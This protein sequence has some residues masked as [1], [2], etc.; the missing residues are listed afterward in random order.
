VL[1]V[2]ENVFYGGQEPNYQLV[3]LLEWIHRKRIDV[4]VGP[5]HSSYVDTG[6]SNEGTVANLPDEVRD[7]ISV[8]VSNAKLPKRHDELARLQSRMSK[9]VEQSR[10]FN[11]D[12]YPKL[13]YSQGELVD[14]LVSSSIGKYLEFKSLSNLLITTG[15]TTHVIPCSKEDIFASESLGLADKRRL[16]KALKLAQSDTPISNSFSEHLSSLGLTDTLQD[17]VAN[18]VAATTS[19]KDGKHFD[20]THAMQRV[21]GFMA[22][23]GRYGKS[24]ILVP[25][26]GGSSEISQAFC[27]YAAV[28]GATYVLGTAVSDVQ[29]RNGVDFVGMDGERMHANRLV[30]GVETAI[31]LGLAKLELLEKVQWCMMLLS[32]KL[33]PSLKLMCNETKVIVLS[34][35]QDTSTCPTDM[36]VLWFATA[37]GTEPRLALESIVSAHLESLGVSKSVEL[38]VFYEQ[39][40]PI[41]TS[42]LDVDVSLRELH[43][44][45]LESSVSSAKAIVSSILGEDLTEDW[46]SPPQNLA[47]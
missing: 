29:L 24:P 16:M 5:L 39:Q 40:V 46:I 34:L 25:M 44:F 18:G 15:E 10:Q 13:L 21:E 1:H 32:A 45:D 27:R 19:I 38:A 14:L 9:L 12:L 2:D 6:S 8:V 17:I 37:A 42:N 36:T 11:L 41:V 20:T 4:T 43:E 31:Q 3:G 33:D 47:Q 35:N 30:V 26:Y 7:L 28:F 22:S 23:V